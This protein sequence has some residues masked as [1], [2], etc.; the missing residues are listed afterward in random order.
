MLKRIISKFSYFYYIATG[1]T[2]PS[3][4]HVAWKKISFLSRHSPVWTQYGLGDVAA[5][6]F[7]WFLLTKTK[8]L[9]SLPSKYLLEGIPSIEI[10]EIL[11]VLNKFPSH[12]QSWIPAVLEIFV[13]TDPFSHFMYLRGPQDLRSRFKI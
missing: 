6:G 5:Q 13:T 4:L 1:P 8:V 10:W 9:D 3:D 2:Q 11:P 7:Q 12:L